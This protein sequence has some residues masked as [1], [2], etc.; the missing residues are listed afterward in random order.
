[1][2]YYVDLRTGSLEDE[3]TLNVN[4][5][6]PELYYEFAKGNDDIYIETWVIDGS[7]RIDVS[8]EELDITLGTV[9]QI[10]EWIFDKNDVK[11]LYIKRFTVPPQK[12]EEILKS[13]ELED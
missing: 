7:R 1:M 10:R 5:L 11:P 13:Y 2:K 12:F 9:N 4:F 8:Y 3:I 6:A